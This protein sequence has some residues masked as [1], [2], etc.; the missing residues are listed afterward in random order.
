[1]R[2]EPLEVAR[3]R[4]REPEEADGHDRRPSARGRP[5]ARP[6]ARSGSP[7]LAISP[8]PQITVSRAEH[9]RERDPRTR[10]VG[11]REQPPER[12]DHA[13]S[14]SGATVA[15]P[16]RGRT[17]RSARR[18]ELGAM[19]DERAR[20]GRARSRSTASADERRALRVEVGG[21][22]VEDERAARR[23]GTPARARSAPLAG[24]QR[25]AA[26]A[27]DRL[28]AVRQRA[29][30]TRPRRRAPPPPARARRARPA[31]PSRMLSATVPRKI[32]GRC[33][34]HATCRR[35]AAVSH[36]A[37][38]TPPTVT[39]PAPGS[40][41]R[42]SSAAIVL[43]P[44]PLSPT[45][46]TRLAR[47]RA[48][49]RARRG[50]R[51]PATGT[52]TRRPRRRPGS[53]PGSAARASRRCPPRA[54][55][56]AASSSRS[57]TARPSA[58]AWNCAPR[59]RSGR[60]SSG[61]STS[62]VSPACR[63]RRPSTSRTPTVTATSATP[64]VA[65]SSSTEPERNATRSVA[66]VVRRYCSLDRGDRLAPARGPRLNARSVGSPRTTSRKCVESSRSACQRS[67]VRL[68]GVAAD[69][70]HEH[71]DERQRDEHHERRGQVD[72]AD[73]REDRDRHDARRARPAAGSA[74][75]TPRA[76]RPL[77]RRGR[78]LAALGPVERGRLRRGG[79]ARR[80]RAAARRGRSRRRGCPATSKPHAARPR[81]ANASRAARARVRRRGAARRRTR[82]R[83]PTRAASPGRG[84][85]APS[86]RPSPT[87]TP[88]STRTARARRTRRGSSARMP[89]AAG[90]SA[91]AASSG[92]GRRR[93]AAGTRGTSRPG[94]G[95]RSAPR[96]PRRR[97][98]TRACSAP[99]R[100][101]ATVRLLPKFGLE[102][103]TRG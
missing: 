37:R 45:S 64:S 94:R 2:R 72:R 102:T 15:L 88:R 78:D 57:A 27:D 56:R 75:S 62:T 50:R 35:H 22:L 33:G 52:R 3:E 73:E 40:A 68:L 17:T 70:P 36:S 31:S 69:Q 7:A 67:R 80:A 87:S 83:R 18:H 13:A 82:G 93:S 92:P 16:R 101:S 63:P 23:G 30:R 66:I 99:T 42:R 14:L 10:R 53:R 9:D 100:R 86:R 98:I 21:R 28:V 71:R 59:V 38:S 81:S 96:S 46:A 103:I 55:R 41:R 32:V 85:A 77:R 24:R 44:A 65:A 26:V 51:P 91:A 5:G 25:P 76:R 89:Y 54:A 49:G 74:R 19:C 60:Y 61:A 11:E 39:R 29:R 8:T 47:A 43:F 79:A 48:R 34:T 4:A 1:M 84:R 97:V 95:A 20:C 12:R 58:L 6:R 90:S